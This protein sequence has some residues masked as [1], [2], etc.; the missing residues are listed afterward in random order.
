ME[1]NLP[2]SLARLDRMY[3]KSNRIWRQVWCQV[4]CQGG[5]GELGDE[6]KKLF[7]LMGTDAREHGAAVFDMSGA[8]PIGE[9]M[10]ARR[11]LET[12]DAAIVGNAEALYE[13]LVLEAIEGRRNGRD[14]RGERA[15]KPVD[16]PRSGFGCGAGIADAGVAWDGAG[17]DLKQADVVGV[18]VAIDA[19]GEEAR[20]ESEFAHEDANGG[21]ERE[22]LR[23]S[24]DGDGGRRGGFAGGH[25]RFLA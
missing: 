15:R 21:V 20:L 1:R 4:W 22:G 13:P 18:E 23:V 3:S 6:P 5:S 19:A 11:Q 2:R 16:G 14:G 9:A 7:T 17:E 25:G 8:K 24:N 10:A 12:Y